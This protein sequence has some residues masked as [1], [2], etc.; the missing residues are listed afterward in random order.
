MTDDEIDAKIAE[1][2]R[3]N[4]AEANDQIDA[5]QDAFSVYLCNALDTLEECG[6]SHVYRAALIR[7]YVDAFEGEYG[8]VERPATPRSAPRRNAKAEIADFERSLGIKR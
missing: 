4:A 5:Y 6:I 7:S 2:A 3:G 8:L 1:I